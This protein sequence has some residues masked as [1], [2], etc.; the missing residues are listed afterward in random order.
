M[1]KIKVENF[2]IRTKCKGMKFG[3]REIRNNSNHIIFYDGVFVGEVRTKTDA[4]K[5]ISNLVTNQKL[6]Y[7]D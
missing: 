4:H 1:E 7:T 5:F 3:D 2:T 6:T